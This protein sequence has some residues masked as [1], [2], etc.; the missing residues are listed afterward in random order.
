MPIREY[1]TRDTG[2][3][4][5]EVFFGDP[6]KVLESSHGRVADLVFSLPANT[7]GKWGDSGERPHYNRGL[8]RWVSGMKEARRIA[9]SRGLVSWQELGDN[10]DQR[11]MM[12][13]RLSADEDRSKAEGREQGEYQANVRRFGGDK[14]RAANETWSAARILSGNTIYSK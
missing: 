10:T 5:E 12:E 6:P 9:D 8:R 1:R 14:A 4:L 13:A 11:N 2:E 3:L 7:P